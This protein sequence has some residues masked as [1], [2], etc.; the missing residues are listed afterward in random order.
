MFFAGSLQGRNIDSTGIPTGV[1]W[2]FEGAEA[3]EHGG[4][5]TS[6]RQSVEPGQHGSDRESAPEKYSRN[7]QADDN[8]E[9]F[10][11]DVESADWFVVEHQ[12]QK[13]DGPSGHGQK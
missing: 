9:L 2:V 10:R 1:F 3:A 6:K 13:P 4:W 8:R 7:A 5:Q 11:T 12:A